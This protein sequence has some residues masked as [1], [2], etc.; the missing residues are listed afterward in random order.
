MQEQEKPRHQCKQIKSPDWEA[1]RN[2]K[3][4]TKVQEA[5]PLQH[6][7]S[8]NSNKLQ[9]HPSNL[10][11]AHKAHQTLPA[12]QP[13]TSTPQPQAPTRPSTAPPC[14]HPSTPS[15]PCKPPRPA[16]TLTPPT[17]S[18]A[19]CPPPQ[20]KATQHH[21]E[22]IPAQRNLHPRPRPM[23]QRLR[24]RLR[25]RHRMATLR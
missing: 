20:T 4:K 19:P 14:S 8:N 23:Q 17:T 16:H 1:S 18:S 6:S 3:L 15:P 5:Q 9:T 24:L 7:T 21:T 12:N 13:A 22:H 10:P 11:P 2:R 25:R